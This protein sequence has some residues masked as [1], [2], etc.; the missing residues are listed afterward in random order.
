MPGEDEEVAGEKANHMEEGGLL[1]VMRKV[2]VP[3]LPDQWK[4]VIMREVVG[5]TS[6]AREMA[7]VEE[8]VINVTGV[9]NGDTN[10]LS[11]QR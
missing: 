3:E 6:E 10:H 8:L 11:V 5:H 2:E 9:I 1:V 4:K 7:E